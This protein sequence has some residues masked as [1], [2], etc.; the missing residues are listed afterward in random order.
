MS[1]AALLQEEQG[2]ATPKRGATGLAAIVD[3]AAEVPERVKQYQ[4]EAEAATFESDHANSFGTLA[5]ETVKGTGKNIFNF[6]TGGTQ[7]FGKTIGESTIA[8]RN[9][10]LYSEASAMHSEQTNMLNQR[11]RELKA[12]GGDT[13]RI[14]AAL[15]VLKES[16]PKIE[17]FTGEVINKTA[18]Q[19]L[20]EGAM[21]ALEALSGG[22]LEGGIKTAAAKE[23]SI[24]QKIVSGIKTGAAFSG[25]GGVAHGMSEG[26]DFKSVALSGLKG[27]AIGAILGGVLEGVGG[28]LANQKKGLRNLIVES[29]GPGVRRVPINKEVTPTNIYDPAYARSKGYEGYVPD[30]MLPEIPFGPKGRSTVPSI[31]MNDAVERSKL[32]RGMKYET[33]PEAQPIRSPMQV[34]EVLGYK[35]KVAVPEIGSVEPRMLSGSDT[36][37]SKLAMGVE[38]KAVKAGLVKDLGDLPDFATTNWE[39]QGQRGAD[40]ASKNYSE[41]IEI[42]MGR[43]NAPNDVLPEAVFK[44]VED[45]ALKNKDIATL[46]ELGTR[47][48][49]LGESRVMGQ[50]IGYLSERL[51]GSPVKAIRE[52]AQVREKAAGIKDVPK[53]KRETM[54]ELKKELAKTRPTKQ[55]WNDFIKDIQC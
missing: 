22:I 40:I 30:S 54:I 29:E 4:R 28:A 51:D 2:G 55:N 47:S 8:P 10:K 24:G 32:P 1:L 44:A 52:V 42:A 5:K 9:A 7:K 15:K 17:E 19:V 41:A 20:G 39:Y 36:S 12:R 27:T 21:T 34:D 23:L 33:I 45:M 31:Q 53:A 37:T 38:A 25:A 3:Q 6:F 46:R 11:L 35:K 50:R 43:K 13:T 48:A 18:E 26:E 49:L 14:E 16:T